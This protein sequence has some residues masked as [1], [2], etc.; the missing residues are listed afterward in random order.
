MYVM[1]CD[2]R[3]AS[4]LSVSI[5]FNYCWFMQLDP[6]CTSKHETIVR[7]ILATC[8]PK[9][10]R[11]YQPFVQAVCAS[12]RSSSP[13]LQ[14]PQYHPLGGGSSSIT[15]T[16]LVKCKRYTP[17]S[18]IYIMKH[19]SFMRTKIIS[20]L[21][22]ILWERFRFEIGNLMLMDRPHYL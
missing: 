17:V 10:N 3:L 11:H 1:Y 5:H 8:H 7:T 16:A 22:S 15:L 19:G 4:G 14:C 9:G 2:K 6:I 20:V 18:Q 21:E 12:I 13:Y